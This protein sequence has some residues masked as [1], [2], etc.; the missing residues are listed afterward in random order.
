MQRNHLTSSRAYLPRACCTISA[1]PGSYLHPYR[2]SKS[3]LSLCHRVIIRTDRINATC[4]MGISSCDGAR[5]GRMHMH[6]IRIET[7]YEIFPIVNAAVAHEDKTWN[8]QVIS[9]QR[10]IARGRTQQRLAALNSPAY[11][12]ST[13]GFCLLRR[14]E[15]SP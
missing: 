13:A 9:C 3:K 5:P 2:R 1:K 14:Q 11:Q 12:N 10:A 6:K 7:S 8:H 15:S 4:Y